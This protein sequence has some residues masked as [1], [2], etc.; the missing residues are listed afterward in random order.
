MDDMLH[1]FEELC[2]ELYGGLKEMFDNRPLYVLFETILGCDPK[3]DH[4]V[5]KNVFPIFCPQQTRLIDAFLL[6]SRTKIIEVFNTE[7]AHYDAI[8]RSKDEEV[9]EALAE[10]EKR[11]CELAAARGL[12]SEFRT[13]LER[14][15]AD[16]KR[17]V[18]RL[19]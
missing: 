15:F 14:Q 2:M 13:Q 5:P 3:H 12:G 4:K 18:G 8:I 19:L 7:L 6:K 16:M 10:I 1:Y 9:E 17:E 11:E